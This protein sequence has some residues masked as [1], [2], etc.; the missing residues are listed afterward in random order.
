MGS[1]P[2]CTLRG[3]DCSPSRT[4]SP[5]QVSGTPTLGWRSYQRAEAPAPLEGTYH[6]AGPHWVLVQAVEQFALAVEVE[7][8]IPA[9][10]EP[11]AWSELLKVA[12][13]VLGIPPA[14]R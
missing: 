8:V 12:R 10:P 6:Q 2:N 11:L 3:P 13:R 4:G 14:D 1:W 7:G 9:L 5:I